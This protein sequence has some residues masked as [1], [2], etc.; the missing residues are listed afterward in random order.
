MT[1]PLAHW[2]RLTAPTT[3]GDLARRQEAVLLNVLA[4]L[5]VLSLATQVAQLVRVAT[6][7]GLVGLA[8]WG[9]NVGFLVA[10]AGLVRLT[11]SGRPRVAAAALISLLGLLG[12]AV[13][14][15]DGID[16]SMWALVFGLCVVLTTILLGGRAGLAVAVAGGTVA[17]L[18]AAL[19]EAGVFEPLVEVRS[20]GT[21][22]SDGLGIFA[23]LGFIAAVCVLYV[24]DVGTSI[25]EILTHGAAASPLR[26]LRTSNLSV[27]EIEVVRL[28]AEGL[29]NDQIAQRLFISSRTVQTHVKNA[30]GKT[31]SVNRTVLG[32]LAVREGLVPIDGGWAA[33]ENGG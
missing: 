25:D 19:I 15:A 12:L 1:S 24:R 4:G 3:D 7:S 20:S 21:L 22:I 33:A 11:R 31:D 30:M 2:R 18:V 29:T 17:V 5:I 10:V 27:R 13:L 23:V 16:N 14:L 32:V 28:I 26:Q 6:G 8:W 9:I